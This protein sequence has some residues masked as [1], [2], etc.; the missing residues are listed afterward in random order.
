LLSCGQ[1]GICGDPS[2]GHLQPFGGSSA[3][4]EIDDRLI[5]PELFT[6]PIRGAEGE[7]PVFNLAPLASASGKVTNGNRKTRFIGQ[8]L[9]LH[10]LK[11]QLGAIATSIVGRDT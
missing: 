1:S 10:F 11:A 9:Q 7:H 8:L 3:R 6:A 4:D 5:I 2:A